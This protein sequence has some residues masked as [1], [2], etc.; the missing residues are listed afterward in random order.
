[1]LVACTCGQQGR[2]PDQPFA[3]NRLADVQTVRH[4]SIAR[5]TSI[6]SL[7][8]ESDIYNFATTIQ[9]NH[10]LLQTTYNEPP[11]MSENIPQSIPTSSTKNPASHPPPPKAHNSKPCS[12]TPIATSK[13]PPVPQPQSRKRLLRLSPMCKVQAQVQARASFTSTRRVAGASMSG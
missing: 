7:T 11:K 13:S 1:V 8:C 12:Q 2:R 10:S 6:H 4:G 3:L 9:Q 5:R